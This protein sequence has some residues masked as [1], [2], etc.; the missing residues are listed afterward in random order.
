MKSNFKGA[1][2]Y[3]KE[4]E[5]MFEDYLVSRK[6]TVTNSDDQRAGKNLYWDLEIE[7]GTR[8]EV[9]YDQKAWMYF[10]MKDHQSSPNLFFEYWSKTRDEKC[11]LYS[12]LGEADIFVYIMKEIDKEG[13][14]TGD[15]AHTFYLEPL[16]LWCESKKF[17]VVPCSTTGDN[18]AEGWL[19]PQSEVMKDRAI[20]GYIKQIKFDR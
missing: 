17:R 15:Y 8:F 7:D 18:N 10:H 12:S 6:H 14:H 16:I 5:R 3:G 4:G 11:G 9:K 1:L 2:G 13:R 19:A 20:N